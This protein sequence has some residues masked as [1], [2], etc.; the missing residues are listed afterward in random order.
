MGVTPPFPAI[1]PVVRGRPLLGSAP[2]MVTTKLRP[3]LTRNYQQYGPVYGISA[4]GMRFVVLAGPEANLFVTK[5]GHKVLRS[6]EAWRQNDIEMG[7]KRSM[8]SLDGEL[9]RKYRRAESRAYSRSYFG[10]NLRAA[11]E[12]TAEDLTPVHAGDTFRVPYWSKRVITEQLARITVG[13]TARPYLED[14]LTFVQTT[15]MVTTT[16]QLPKV[17]LLQPKVR[18]AKARIFKMVDDLIAQHRANPAEAAG[19]A[20][21]LIDDVLAAEKTD[22]ELWQHEDI[23]IAALGSFIAG[24][25]TAANSLSFVLYRM[26]KHKEYLPKLRAEADALFAAGPP[27]AEA[28]GRSPLLHTFVMETLRVHPIAPAMS[29]TLTTEVEFAGHRL[30]ARTNVIVGTTVSHGLD[31][32]YPNPDQFDPA[33]FGPERAEHRKPGAY[34]PFGLGAHTCAGSGMAEGLIM[35]NAAAILYTL[36]LEL[37]PSY[38]FKE[39]ARPTPSPADDLA[40]RVVGVRH[41]VS[42]LF[43]A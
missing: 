4:V 17:M 22:P 37:D 18:R 16:K 32:F 7:A 41:P 8:I 11:L 9:H 28:L 35:L 31:Q 1:L 39:I 26:H 40:L 3:F 13:G 5:E 12:V 36:E 19:R 27:S 14:M 15:L 21:D 2:D 34:A 30:P 38:Q 33:R 24:M 23:R 25:D 20:P 42:S 43:E 29:R 6:E 10:E